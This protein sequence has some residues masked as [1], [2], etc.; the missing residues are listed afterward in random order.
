MLGYQ[1]SRTLLACAYV[2]VSQC[3]TTVKN[4]QNSV[5]IQDVLPEAKSEF[6]TR[7]YNKIPPTL[8]SDINGR[9]I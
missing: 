8:Y 5:T 7:A 2:Q 3:C 1:T 4:T 6:N 9:T